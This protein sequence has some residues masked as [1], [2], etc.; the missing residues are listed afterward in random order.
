MEYVEI[1]ESIR[2]SVVCY[3]VTFLVPFKCRT[4]DVFINR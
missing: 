1:M 2:S 4:E 3:C